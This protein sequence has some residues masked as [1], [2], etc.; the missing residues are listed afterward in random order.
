ML[1]FWIDQGSQYASG[2]KFARVMN[3]LG[4]HWVLNMAE[5]AWLY[6]A[7]YAWK[8]LNVPGYARIYVNLLN[9]FFYIFR[10]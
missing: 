2:S 4:L 8:P 7:E 9:G 1:G 10:L 5:Y 3:M 6:L